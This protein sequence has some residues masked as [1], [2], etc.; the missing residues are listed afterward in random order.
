MLWEYTGS[1]DKGQFTFRQIQTQIYR[2][3]E[4]N[5]KKNYLLKLTLQISNFR[6]IF[7]ALEKFGNKSRKIQ[8]FIFLIK[9]YRSCRCEILDIYIHF[10]SQI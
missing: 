1:E 6:L 3:E 8:A 10:I 9:I 5:L 2:C 4:N 7:Y